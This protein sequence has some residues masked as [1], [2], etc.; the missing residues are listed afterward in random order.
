MALEIGPSEL[1]DQNARTVSCQ[2]KYAPSHKEV[3]GVAVD[4]AGHSS[5]YRV[6]T[7][8][9]TFQLTAKGTLTSFM[10]SF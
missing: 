1:S 7:M 8:L 5:A 10:F 4:R 2:R 3:E 6:G 9:N